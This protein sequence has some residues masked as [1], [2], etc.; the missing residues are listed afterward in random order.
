MS[1]ADAGGRVQLAVGDRSAFSPK[2][3]TI[4]TTT[5]TAPGVVSNA[6][7]TNDNIKPT[8]ESLE[9]AAAAELSNSQIISNLRDEIFVS[10]GALSVDDHLLRNPRRPVSIKKTKKRRGKELKTEATKSEVL[11]THQL[12]T[13]QRPRTLRQG[14]GLPKETHK[15]TNTEGNKAHNRE[16]SLTASTQDRTPTH[17]WLMKT[18]GVGVP[19]KTVSH[20]AK[21]E[22]NASFT[23]DRQ[24]QYKL[25]E[26]VRRMYHCGRAWRPTETL[27]SLGTPIEVRCC[28]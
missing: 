12:Q 14:H 7:S 10:P 6:T 25:S 16:E 26:N 13:D 9:T 22:E 28:L 11:N 17:D 3:S 19:K 18:R 5:T 23:C 8:A 27:P 2:P 20:S 21:S 4:T 24:K 1:R 15:K